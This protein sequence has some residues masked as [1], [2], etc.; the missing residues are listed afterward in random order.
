MIDGKDDLRKQKP[1]LQVLTS[2]SSFLVS[3]SDARGFAMGESTITPSGCG[4]S[5]SAPDID[6]EMNPASPY[7][8]K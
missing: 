7:S 5:S 6:H 2:F 8:T 3:L 1:S 4:S